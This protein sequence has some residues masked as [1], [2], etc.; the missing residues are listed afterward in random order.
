MQQSGISCICNIHNV[1]G[2]L[3]NHMHAKLR[4]T[5]SICEVMEIKEMEVN[6]DM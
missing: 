6:F 3:Q 1:Y 4:K 2:I 5:S